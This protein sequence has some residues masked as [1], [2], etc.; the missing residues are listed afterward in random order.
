MFLEM[1]IGL[2]KIPLT[3]DLMHSDWR[4][5]D[6]KHILKC[7]KETE[8]RLFFGHTLQS[9]DT[10]HPLFSKFPIWKAKI[11]REMEFRDGTM[12]DAGVR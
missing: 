5:I 6:Q 1:H 10:E 9:P 2:A 7:K 11:R 12:V 3:K 8:K 4:Q